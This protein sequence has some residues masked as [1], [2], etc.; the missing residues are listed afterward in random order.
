MEKGYIHLK[1]AIPID[2]VSEARSRAITL[3]KFYKDLEGQDRHNGS[4]RFW[5][6]LEL[7]STLDPNLFKL[8]T[9]SFMHDIAC[10]YLYTDK[11]Y[12]FND[13]VVVKLPNEKFSFDPHWDNQFGPDPEGALK[14]EF[15]TINCCWIL[16]N[17]PEETGPLSIKNTITDEYDLVPANAGDIVII[18]GNTWH[19]STENKSD[20][21]RALYACIYSSKP[22]GNFQKG[23]YNEEFIKK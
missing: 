4:G 6:G 12:L 16:T 8:Y 7:A 21:I 14:G 15:K 18:D 17:M 22:I 9:A 13:Q 20:K 11:P 10:R 1:N 3:K 5:K 19:S 2:M 23:Y